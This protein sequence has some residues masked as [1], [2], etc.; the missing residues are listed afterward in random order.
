MCGRRVGRGIFAQHHR[1]PQPGRVVHYQVL[2]DVGAGL[3]LVRPAATM[4]VSVVP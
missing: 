2:Q 1:H 3:A 4:S